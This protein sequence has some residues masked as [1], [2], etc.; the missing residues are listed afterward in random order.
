MLLATTA[1]SAARARAALLGRHAP[2]SEPAD[3][4]R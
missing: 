3:P 2:T 4:R 1:I